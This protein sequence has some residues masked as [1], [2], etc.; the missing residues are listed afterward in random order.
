MSLL[1]ETSKG[2]QNMPKELCGDAYLR[3]WGVSLSPTL[4]GVGGNGKYKTALQRISSQSL[5]VLAQYR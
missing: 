4:G 1:G 2:Q 3:T 5:F